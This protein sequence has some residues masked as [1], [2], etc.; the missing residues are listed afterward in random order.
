MLKLAKWNLILFLS[1][2]FIISNCA[3]V[4]IGR[5]DSLFAR[6]LE[7]DKSD[8][9]IIKM[10]IKI[11]HSRFTDE[12]FAHDSVSDSMYSVFPKF[13]KEYDKKIGYFHLGGKIACGWSAINKLKLLDSSHVSVVEINLEEIKWGICKL[14][15]LAKDTGNIPIR[16][17]FANDFFQTELKV[18]KDTVLFEDRFKIKFERKK[19]PLPFL[20]VVHLWPFWPPFN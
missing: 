19:W 9:K 3:Y 10:S 11:A 2:A 20:W 12:Y 7:R 17:Y 18:S 13:R 5:S 8:D 4:T 15:L 6:E 14:K 1:I 16:I